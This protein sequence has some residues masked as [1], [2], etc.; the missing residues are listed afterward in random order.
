VNRGNAAIFGALN[1]QVSHHAGYRKDSDLKQ[2]EITALNISM[3]LQ[4]TVDPEAW[5]C[6]HNIR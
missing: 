3:P 2:C 5:L 4:I 1:S 6:R